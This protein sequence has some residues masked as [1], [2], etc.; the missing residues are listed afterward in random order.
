MI[1]CGSGTEPG[2]AISRRFC[3]LMGGDISIE[4]EIDRG[5]TF[6]ICLPA[7]VLDA[8]PIPS[9]RHAQA[10]QAAGAHS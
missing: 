1:I 7:E 9:A 8:Q 2:L 10:P 5:S 4:S 6:T 3:Q